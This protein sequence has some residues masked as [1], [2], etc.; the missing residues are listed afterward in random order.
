MKETN[1]IILWNESN[2]WEWVYDNSNPHETAWGS[3]NY[4]KSTYSI[5][6]IPE[7]ME[8]FKQTP[9]DDLLDRVFKTSEPSV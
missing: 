4:Q 5:L 9:E 7:I 8:K 6:E 3:K 2:Q 1:M